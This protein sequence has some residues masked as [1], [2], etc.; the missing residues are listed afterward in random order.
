MITWDELRERFQ[1]LPLPTPDDVSITLDGRRLDTPAKVRAFL[2]EV[3]SVREA[4]QEHT[5][6]L[7]PSTAWSRQRR[8]SRTYVV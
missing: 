8:C 5:T 7:T 2:L 4:E 3:A 6:G 1:D